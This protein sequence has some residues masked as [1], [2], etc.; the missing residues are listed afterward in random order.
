MAVIANYIR[1]LTVTTT[2]W[3]NAD[4]IHV[5]PSH[6]ITRQKNIGCRRRSEMESERKKWSIIC[7]END[8]KRVGG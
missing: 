6:E 1:L 2:N 8:R 7:R 3:P 5:S 4:R